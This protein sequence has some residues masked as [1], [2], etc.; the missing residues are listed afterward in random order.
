MKKMFNIL[1]YQENANQNYNN[2]PLNTDYD[3]YN[4]KGGE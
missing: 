4:K 3:G 1:N 2:I